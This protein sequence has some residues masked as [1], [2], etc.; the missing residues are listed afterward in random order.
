MDNA[1]KLTPSGGELRLRLRR[2]DEQIV[3]SV[4]DTGIGI[5]PE[6]RPLLFQRFHRGRNAASYPGSGLALAI[7]R[8]IAQPHHLP[9]A[10][11]SQRVEFHLPLRI[12]GGAAIRPCHSAQRAN[13]SNALRARCRSRSRHTSAHSSNG[14]LSGTKNCAR[15]SR[16]YSARAACRRSAQAAHVC[17]LRCG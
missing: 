8:A 7:V 17:Q 14:A 4:E 6:D 12:P 3:L 11:L 13:R 16:R 1:I 10:H 5:P 15:K 2:A 9:V